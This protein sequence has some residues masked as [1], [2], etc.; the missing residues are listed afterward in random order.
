MVLSGIYVRNWVSD[1]GIEVFRLDLF[2]GIG[3]GVGFVFLGSSDS[4]EKKKIRIGELSVFIKKLDFSLRKVC[5]S[6]ECDFY[7]CYFLNSFVFF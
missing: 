2:F 1:F 3:F 7:R 6:S 4:F 5:F